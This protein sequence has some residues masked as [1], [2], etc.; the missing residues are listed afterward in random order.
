MED[1]ME[2]GYSDQ[3]ISEF[4]EAV[5]QLQRFSNMQVRIGENLRKGN[6]GAMR[7]ELDNYEVELWCDAKRCDKDKETKFMEILPRLNKEIAIAVINKNFNEFYNKLIEKWKTLREVQE[8]AGKGSRL[9]SADD[10]Y[11]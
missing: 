3:K 6:L 11:M 10:D 9:K 2:E 4:N 1:S 5:F 8:E 7:W